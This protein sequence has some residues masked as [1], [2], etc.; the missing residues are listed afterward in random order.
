MADFEGFEVRLAGP[1]RRWRRCRRKVGSLESGLDTRKHR[2]YG[3]D[4]R[5]GSRDGPALLV[6][7]PEAP[8][9]R[10][11]EVLQTLVIG[12]AGEGDPKGQPPPGSFFEKQGQRG[13]PLTP[14]AARTRP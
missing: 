7:V 2:A 9:Q 12:G 13:R 5:L 6:V 3:V 4:G 14:D 10:L 11:K 8:W 1:L